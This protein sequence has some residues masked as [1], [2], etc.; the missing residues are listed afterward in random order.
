MT[1]PAQARDA[2]LADVALSKPLQLERALAIITARAA[3]RGSFSANDLR[4][5]MVAQGI[6]GPVRGAAFMTAKVRG[7]IRAVGAETSTDRGTHHKGIARYEGTDTHR[8]VEVARDD[9]GRFAPE[10]PPAGQA[11]IFEVSP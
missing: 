6:S 8:S 10:P 1:A 4:E 3:G 5:E 2:A 9:L 11:A 7:L